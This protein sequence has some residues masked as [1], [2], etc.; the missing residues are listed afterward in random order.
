MIKS[1]FSCRKVNLCSVAGDKLDRRLLHSNPVIEKRPLPPN[2]P[3][4]QET[5]KQVAAT[6]ESYSRGLSRLAADS[7]S[8]WT[9]FFAKSKR[10][11]TLNLNFE[12]FIGCSSELL[13]YTFKLSKQFLCETDLLNLHIHLIQRTNR[14]NKQVR[15]TGL[16][17]FCTLSTIINNYCG[18][19]A[20]QSVTPSRIQLVLDLK[21]W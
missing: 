8:P 3:T 17:S 18:G 10:K 7:V 2:L 15:L 16:H 21:P 1:K 19:A 13:S 6:S 5:K 12:L 4:F 9:F 20:R 14:R 11:I